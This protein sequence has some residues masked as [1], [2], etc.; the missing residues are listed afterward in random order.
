MGGGAGEQREDEEQGSRLKKKGR[1]GGGAGRGTAFAMSPQNPDQIIFHT[2]EGINT[3]QIPSFSS[4]NQALDWALTWGPI[5]SVAQLDDPHSI[6]L[7][8]GPGQPPPSV[9]V[10]LAL[11][12]GP[13]LRL[14]HSV[15]KGDMSYLGLLSPAGRVG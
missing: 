13:S 2:T 14:S 7:R 15:P 9:A 12:P 5:T 4:T 3:T 8:L 6:L 11:C 1:S 10:G